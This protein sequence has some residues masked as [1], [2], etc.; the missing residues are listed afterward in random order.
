MRR[1]NNANPNTF[2]HTHTRIG[3][4]F[5]RFDSFMNNFYHGFVRH[6]F[7][8]SFENSTQIINTDLI[9]MPFTL[10]VSVLFHMKFRFIDGFI[11]TDAHAQ[12]HS[13]GGEC[14]FFSS[15]LLSFVLF[16]LSSVELR[17]SLNFVISL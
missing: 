9:S 3:R 5:F 2:T 13:I 4:V 1:Y 7:L 6:S 12:T 16:S 17:F 10:C 14:F 11:R 15:F 8:L